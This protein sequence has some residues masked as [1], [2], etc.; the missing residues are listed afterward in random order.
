MVEGIGGG[1]ECWGSGSCSWNVK[2]GFEGFNVGLKAD[3]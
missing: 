1:I 3:S 2:G